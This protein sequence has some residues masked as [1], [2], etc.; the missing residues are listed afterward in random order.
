MK[1]TVADY[2][3]EFLISK[4][5]TDVFGYQGGMITYLFDSFKKYD[6]KIRYHIPYNEQG[7]AFAACGYAQSSGK[8]GF[9]FVTSGPGF[10]NLATGI[11]DAYFDSIPTMFISAQV[12]FKDKRHGAAYRQKGFQEI[13]A[14]EIAKPMVKKS[15]DIDTGDQIISALTEAYEIAMGGRKGP[16]FLEIP[17][18]VF[19]DEIDVSDFKTNNP[20]LSAKEE[21]FDQI[22]RQIS[23]AKRPLIIAGAGVDQSC[24]RDAFRLFAK[25][26][27]M[28]VVTTLP[29]VDL[30]PSDSPFNFEYIGASGRRLPNLLLKETDLVLSIGTRL[31]TRQVGHHLDCFAPKAK[32]IRLDID[33]SEFDRKIKED[34]LQ[35]HTEIAPFLKYC[36]QEKIKFPD[37]SNWLKK[38]QSARELLNP[39][40]KSEG[41]LFAEKITA[42]FPT[43][44]NVVLDVG[45][46]EIWCAQSTVVKEQTRVYLSAGLGSMGYSLPS[47]IGAYYGNRRPT[48]SFNGDGGIQMNIQELQTI[49]ENHLPIKIFVLNNRALGMI[50]LFQDQYFE[51]R[52]VADKDSVGDYHSANIVRIA[53]AYGIKGRKIGSLSEVASVEKDLMSSDPMVFEISLANDDEPILPGIPAGSDPLSTGEALP[54]TVVSQLHELFVS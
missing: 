9:A 49:A 7:A 39:F 20:V 52:Y 32:L 41:N 48:F 3:V 33:C 2:I 36:L 47:A 50:T 13:N 40:D 4:G 11:A 19:R 35:V 44:A 30:L 25:K 17:I 22:I 14:P 10:T 43:D 28:P 6:D 23:L 18:N 51:S 1:L 24:Q 15:Y 34:E 46:N 8:L 5:V 29:S 54:S 27:G 31:S 45:K 53:E 42:M 21:I 16:V 12:N 26:A 38:C 37:F